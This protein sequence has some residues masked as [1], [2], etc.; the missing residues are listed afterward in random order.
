VLSSTQIVIITRTQIVLKYYQHSN[1]RKYYQHSNTRKHYQ[2]SNITRI[3]RYEPPERTEEN[4]DVV[5]SRLVLQA[6]EVRRHRERAVAQLFRHLET[7]KG[8]DLSLRWTLGSSLNFVK[9]KVQMCVVCFERPGTVLI[10]SCGHR[11]LCKQ[12]TLNI[13][14]VNPRCPVCREWIGSTATSLLSSSST[15]CEPCTKKKEDC[16]DS[17]S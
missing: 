17:S 10:L 4:K 2:H 1:T 9:D 5:F 8:T 14:L 15:T 16:D 13:Q 11:I 6:H 3:H 7:K 12:C